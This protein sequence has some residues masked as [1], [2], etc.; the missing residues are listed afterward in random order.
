MKSLRTNIVRFISLIA[1]SLICC[2]S[3]NSQDAI[4]TATLNQDESLLNANISKREEVDKK[5]LEQSKALESIMSYISGGGLK[6]VVFDIDGARKAGFDS[7]IIELAEQLASATNAL[8]ENSASFANNLE[9]VDISL[10]PL[11][12]EQFPALNNYFEKATEFNRKNQLLKD[13]IPTDE[14]T[15]ETAYS[16]C[17]FYTNPLPSRAAPWRTFY[18]ISNPDSTLRS[19]G[20]HGT[21]NLVGGGYTRAQTYSWFYC[22]FGTFR[23]HAYIYQGNKIKEQNYSGW[24]PRGEPNPEVYASGPWPYAV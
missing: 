9:E 5:F 21:L 15:I 3:G 12:L 20:Y 14:F 4:K 17:G 23:D 22:G 19:W 8:L 18:N 1:L 16:K 7:E 10:V 13:L 2:F 6:P 24:T 11:D